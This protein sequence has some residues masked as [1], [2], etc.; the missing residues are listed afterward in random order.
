MNKIW[1][2][3]RRKITERD[4]KVFFCETGENINQSV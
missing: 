3:V 4:F 1:M 2:K